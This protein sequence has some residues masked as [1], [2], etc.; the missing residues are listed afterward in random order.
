MSGRY[1]LKNKGIRLENRRQGTVLRT[2]PCPR[3]AAGSNLET[4]PHFAFC[5]MH[6]VS[7]GSREGFF[8]LHR[9]YY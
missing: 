1:K 7:F 3:P 5:I 2:V 8:R 9:L 4:H 6:L